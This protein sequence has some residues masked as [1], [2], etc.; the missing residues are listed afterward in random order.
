MNWHRIMLLLG[1]D[2]FYALSRLRAWVFLV[3]FFLCWYTIHTQ[4]KKGVSE[5]LQSQEGILV[6]S[7]IYGL[8]GAVNLFVTHP[9]TVSVF[10]LVTLSSAPFFAVLAGFDQF[11]SD[12]GN[13]YFRFLST[14]CSRLEICCARFLSALLLFCSALLL[15]AG[16]TAFLSLMNDDYS[17]HEIMLYTSQV[18]AIT[19]LYATAYLAYM[20]L[21]SSMTA[22]AIGSLFLGYF[23]Y[24]VVW[25]AGFFFVLGNGKPLASYLLVSAHRDRLLSVETGSIGMGAVLLI[26]YSVCYFLLAFY[27]FRRRN[28]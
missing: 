21:I 4:L 23:G 17:R 24:A 27:F 14:R 25:F 19:A 22:S 7:K 15:V 8:D 10:F 2:L 11:S 12:T 3:P 6:T 5:I 1:A 16:A 18:Y 13:G 28:L 9:P 26:L 20:S